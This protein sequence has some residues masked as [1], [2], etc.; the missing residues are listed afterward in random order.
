MA[1]FSGKGEFTDEYGN[2][3]VGW[4][5]IQPARVGWLTIVLDG[6]DTGDVTK[7]ER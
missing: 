1:L 3:A 7:Y 2:V 6:S 4:D 5:V